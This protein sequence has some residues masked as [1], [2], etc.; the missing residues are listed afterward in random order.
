ML[1]ATA[2]A[3]AAGAAPAN[4]I[5]HLTY[6]DAHGSCQDGSGNGGAARVHVDPAAPDQE[7]DLLTVDEAGS[8][9][10][11]VTLFATGTAADASDGSPGDEDACPAED[12]PDGDG[13][14]ENEDHVSAEVVALNE[15]VEAGVCYDNEGFHATADCHGGNAG[16]P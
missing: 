7:I 3:L 11:A 15:N 10:D 9:A 4:A 12:D 13:T 16:L 14:E 6:V 8:A 1:L 2:V 5:I